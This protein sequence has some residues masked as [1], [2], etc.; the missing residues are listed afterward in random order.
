MM[1]CLSLYRSTPLYL[2]GSGIFP[3]KSQRRR[4]ATRKRKANRQAKNARTMGQALLKKLVIRRQDD[5]AWKRSRMK[6]RRLYILCWRRIQYP[7]STVLSF[8]I[9]LNYG[10]CAL[11][12]LLIDVNL[13]CR[14]S[15]STESRHTSRAVTCLRR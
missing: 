3:R 15:I 1:F 14:L 5:H 10:S 11:F 9:H 13:N 7:T 6:M 8:V 4:K 12:T 2:F